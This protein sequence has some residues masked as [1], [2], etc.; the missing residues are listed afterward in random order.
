MPMFPKFCTIYV[1]YKGNIK[2][3]IKKAAINQKER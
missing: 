2:I 3:K 1:Y